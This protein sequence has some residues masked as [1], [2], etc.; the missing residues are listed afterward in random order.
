MYATAE[1]SWGSQCEGLGMAGSEELGG[2]RAE[3][4]ACREEGMEHSG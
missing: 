3:G 4:R 1:A 2:Q